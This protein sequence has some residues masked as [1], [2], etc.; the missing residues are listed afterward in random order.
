MIQRG[1]RRHLVLPAIG[2]LVLL[3]LVAPVSHAADQPISAG[4][5][6]GITVD[7]N[8]ADWD[9]AASLL[10][11]IHEDGDTREGHPRPGVRPVRLRLRDRS[12]S[13]SRPPPAGT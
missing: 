7:G 5:S 13:S 12:I 6:A 8:A 2:A 3:A 4:P 10:G 1:A 11:P 9:L